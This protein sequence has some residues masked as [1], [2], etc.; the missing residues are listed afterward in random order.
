MAGELVDVED[1]TIEAE[2]VDIE[3]DQPEPIPMYPLLCCGPG[4]HEPAD[5]VLGETSIDGPHDGMRCAAEA[6]VPCAPVIAPMTIANLQAQLA[7]I[8]VELAAMKD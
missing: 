5:G 3:P 2:A 8:A 4:P 6:C 7:A 1:P